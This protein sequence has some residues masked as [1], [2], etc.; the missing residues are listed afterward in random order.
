VKISSITGVLVL[1]AALVFSG[2]TVKN[3]QGEP[4]VMEPSI[5]EELQPVHPDEPVDYT[6]NQRFSVDYAL[7]RVGMIRDVSD[8]LTGEAKMSFNNSVGAITGTLMKQEYELRKAE[9]ELAKW[10]VR[11]GQITQ[12][13]FNQIEQVYRNAMEEF[14]N[15]WDTFGISD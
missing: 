13:E 5:E 12:E 1:C 10:Q 14:K 2:C 11:E 7:G 3:D 15:F 4:I 8:L 9:F 6:Y